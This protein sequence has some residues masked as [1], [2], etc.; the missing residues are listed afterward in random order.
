M[1][2]KQIHRRLWA[3]CG[4]PVLICQTGDTDQLACSWMARSVLA[5]PR[6]D[7]SVLWAVVRANWVPL[8]LEIAQIEADGSGSNRVPPGKGIG[9]AKWGHSRSQTCST[10]VSV[11][12][13]SCAATLFFSSHPC[14]QTPHPLKNC[15]T[16]SMWKGG[17]WEGRPLPVSGAQLC[18]QNEWAG[19]TERGSLRLQQL[20][21]QLQSLKGWICF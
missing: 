5:A 15:G 9:P 21:S 2:I 1:V 19:L 3:L 16:R 20:C 11:F 12:K 7:F 6:S 14:S 8:W 4:E 17:A 10:L 18:R 13:S